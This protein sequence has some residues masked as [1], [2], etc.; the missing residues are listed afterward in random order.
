MVSEPT[1]PL[2]LDAIEAHLAEAPPLPSYR[3]VLRLVVEQHV[4]ALIAEVRRLRAVVT[5]MQ[6]AIDYMQRYLPPDAGYYEAEE[7]DDDSTPEDTARMAD[8]HGDA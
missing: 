6:Q 4:P 3:T 5:Q 8:G 2:D 7:E 1:A